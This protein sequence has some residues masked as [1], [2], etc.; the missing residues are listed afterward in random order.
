MHIGSL[1]ERIF[2]YLYGWSLS[3]QF[4]KTSSPKKSNSLWNS[5]SLAACTQTKIAPRMKS[6]YPT[7]FVRTRDEKQMLD[8]RDRRKF[9]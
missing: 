9:W 7:E 2:V 8:K 3:N 6:E 4:L 1:R 5:L